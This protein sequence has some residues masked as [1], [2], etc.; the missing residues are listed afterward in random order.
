MH[1][2]NNKETQEN[3]K[4]IIFGYDSK[5]KYCMYCEQA[6]MF[7]KRNNKEFVFYPIDKQENVEH[8]LS[9]LNK[10]ELKGTTMPQIFINSTHIGGFS[11]LKE[12][13]SSGKT[14]L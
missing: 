3:S 9:L 10:T 8:L 5:H 1:N 7:L 13:V 4:I 6:K 12:Q 2:S 14:V 11:D